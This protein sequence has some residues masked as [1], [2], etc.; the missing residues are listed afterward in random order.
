MIY[1]WAEAS[2]NF[3][4]EIEIDPLRLSQHFKQ[5]QNIC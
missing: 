4:K 1:N 5:V 3:N 2:S